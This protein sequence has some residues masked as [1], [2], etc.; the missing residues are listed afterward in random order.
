MLELYHTHNSVCAQKVRIVLA[1]KGL[2][3]ESHHLLLA[4]GEHQTPEYFKLNPKG[5]VP[6]LLD[7]GEVVRESTII[8]EYLD[9][10]YRDPSLMPDTSLDRAQA[11]LWMKRIDDD[12]HEPATTTV[13]FAIALRHIFMEQG[14]EACEAWIDKIPTEIFRD[15]YRDMVRNGL[16]SA[17][18]RP[19]LKS[20]KKLFEDLDDRLTGR[21]WLAG[22][23]YSLADL[24]YA[25]YLTRFE[26][27][28]LITL[29]EDYPNLA[30]WYGRMKSRPA[31]DAAILQWDDPHYVGVMREQGEK[32]AP[33]IRQIFDEL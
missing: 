1:E 20:F 3:W 12:I 6:T 8:I 9:D 14:E 26:R 29:I 21:D 23:D 18:F 13:S 33:E 19:G 32:A 2:E 17:D 16:E 25:P 22:N 4:K 24:S 30:N 15:R 27:L 10:T 7:N 31:Y 11:R 5:V 28:S